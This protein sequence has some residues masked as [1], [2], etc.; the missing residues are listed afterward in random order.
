MKRISWLDQRRHPRWTNFTAE[1][2]FG[3]FA[4]NAFCVRNNTKT[5]S[6]M[7][8]AVNLGTPSS[9]SEMQQL[10]IPNFTHIHHLLEF[11]TICSVELVV[12]LDNAM[13]LFQ[14]RCG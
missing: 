8:Y 12:A 6:S 11:A 9:Y 13:E 1:K 2:Y 4:F 14:L 3:N 10:G 5:I 7:I